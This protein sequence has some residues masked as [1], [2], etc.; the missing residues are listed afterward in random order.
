MY[1]LILDFGCGIYWPTRRLS[2]QYPM[3]V[4]PNAF[5]HCGV[6]LFDGGIEWFIQDSPGY[7]ILRDTLFWDTGVMTFD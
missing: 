1:L 3:P 2:K 4:M 6:I 7:S 5:I